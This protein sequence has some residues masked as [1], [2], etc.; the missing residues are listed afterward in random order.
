MATVS[1]IRNNEP[2][3]NPNAAKVEMKLEV[4]IIPVSDVDRAK[5]FC[6]GLLWRLD[7]DFPVGNDWRV[8]QFTPPAGLRVLGDIRKGRHHGSA[9]LCPGPVSRS[10]RYCAEVRIKPLLGM[11]K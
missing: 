11:A 9:R 6:S 1:S 7:A 8:V 10:L 4:V 5:E 3:P 2:T